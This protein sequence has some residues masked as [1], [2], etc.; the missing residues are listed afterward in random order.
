MKSWTMFLISLGFLAIAVSPQM[1]TPMISVIAGLVMILA[2]V[3]K[4]KR[5]N[6]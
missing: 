4:L 1:S 5:K 2:G 3:I 6:K